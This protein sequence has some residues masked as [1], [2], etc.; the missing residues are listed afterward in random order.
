[1]NG[2]KIRLALMN[3]LQYAIWGAYLIS[4]GK[5]LVSIH[6][7][8]EIPWFYSVQGIV[9]IFMPAIIGVMGDKYMQPQKLLGLCHL[10]AAGFMGMAYYYCIS[11]PEPQFGTLFTYYTLSVGFYMPTIA[12]SNTVA[13]S[14]LRQFGLDTIKDFPPIRV[15]GTVGF[16]AS[17]WFVNSAYINDGEFGL[18]LTVADALRFQSNSYQ[19]LVCAVLGL[20]LAVYAYMLPQCPLSKSDKKQTLAEKF[21]LDA[22][23]LFKEKKMALFFLF[24]ML[25]GVSLQITNAYASSFITHFKDVPE[26]ANSFVVNNAT[27]L[28]SLSQISEAL[29]I[30]LIPFFLKQFGIKK[31][32]MI[33]M[34]AWVLRFGFFGI[35]DPGMPGVLLFILSMIV[36]GVA[37]DFFNVSGALFV[38]QEAPQKFQSSAQGLFMLMTNGIGAT[39]GTQAAGLVVNHFCHETENGTLIGDWSTV[40]LIFAAYAFVV[41]ALFTVFFKYKHVRK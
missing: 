3:F 34:F 21:G 2:I 26:Y 31:V 17:M 35:G 4:M 22:F 28:I 40:W 33:A 18:S 24:S 41:F 6:L 16:I 9:S 8:K 30:L 7:A 10:L 23:V 14:I 39:V 27:L 19:F 12:L 5:Y 20:V 11:T 13:F 25:L 36:Y 1:M 38:S 29:C 15:L 32:M 37:F